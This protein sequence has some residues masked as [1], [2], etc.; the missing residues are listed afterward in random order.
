MF[1]EG[2]VI[3]FIVGLAVGFFSAARMILSDQEQSA[4]ADWWE[5]GWNQCLGPTNHQTPGYLCRYVVSALVP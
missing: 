1:V 3:A 5:Q 4:Q 2:Y